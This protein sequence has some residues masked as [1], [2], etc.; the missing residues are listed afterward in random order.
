MGLGSCF[1]VSLE[2]GRELAIDCRRL[3]RQGIDPIEVRRT[4][5]TQAALNATKS[6]LFTKSAEDYIK[7]HGAGWRL[8][9]SLFLLGPQ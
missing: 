1:V 6:I 8:C 7:S 4:A 5:K 3:R 9:C 2:Q